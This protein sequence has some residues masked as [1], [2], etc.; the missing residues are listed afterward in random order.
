MSSKDQVPAASPSAGGPGPGRPLAG[1]ERALFAFSR[2]SPLNLVVLARLAGPALDGL[3]P[4]ALAALQERHPLLRARV[5][6]PPSRPRFDVSPAAAAPGGPGPIPLRLLRSPDPGFAVGV[7]KEEMNAPFDAGRGPLARLTCLSGA[8]PGSDLVLTLHHAIADGVSTANLI[9]ELL[10][11]CQARIAGDAPPP[12][13]PLPA[14]PPLTGV[15]PP[16]SRGIRRRPQELALALRQGRGEIAY[17]WGSRGQRRPIPPPGQAVTR[18]LS[19]DHDSTAVLV[20]RARRQRLTLTGLL[21]AALLWQVSAVLYQSR[22]CTMQ[23]IVWV[24]LRPH[25]DPPVGSETLGCY[26]S[27][28][29][30]PIRVDP[31]SGFAALATQVQDGIEQAT[32]RGDRIAAALVTGGLAPL[33]IRWP[34]GRLGTTALS[35]AAAPAIQPSYGTVDVR[36]VRAFVSNIRLGAELAATAGL[37]QGALWCNLLY[38]DSDVGEKTA[39]TIGDGLLSTLREF[40]GA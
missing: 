31:G 10:A 13:A 1:M 32:R 17:R 22:P 36:E 9:H 30:L 24:D 3:L 14:P 20:D 23:A 35:Y 7:A 15:L 33:A 34:V 26:I 28:L 37:A 29:R 11:W 12:L 8:G 38:L 19:L 25:L 18:A 39:A 5:T 27:M 2:L 6:G 16:G 21:S 40:T 4:Q